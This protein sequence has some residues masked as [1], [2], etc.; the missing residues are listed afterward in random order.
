V[1]GTTGAATY[2]Y[3]WELSDQQALAFNPWNLLRAT[4]TG[5]ADDWDPAGARDRYESAGQGS[6]VFRVTLSGTPASVRTGGP[7]ATI[8]AAVAPI[9]VA[10]PSITWST[11]SSEIMLSRTTGPDVVVTGNL[12][13]AATPD[14]VPVIATAA[15]GFHATAWVYVE[16]P[17][18]APPVLTQG[19]TLT[20]P[21]GGQMAVD[22]AYDLGDHTDQSIITWSICADATCATARDVATSRDGLPL[23]SHAL[24]EGDVGQ[25]IR[26][27]VQP[28]HNVSD[29]G[30]AVFAI[31]DK[32]IAACDVASTTVSPNFRNFVTTADASYVSGLWTVIGTWTVQAGTTLVNGYGV[33]VG[34]QGAALLYQDDTRRGD[35]QV[36]VTMTPEKTS[37]AGFGS[38]GSSA[39]GAN[40]QKSDI[41]IKYDPRT[42]T[43]YSLRFW[44]TTQSASA[45][46]F[47]LFRIDN[48]IGT[49]LND[50]QVLTG[51]FRDNTELVMKVTG[52]QLT[53]E[54]HNT[55]NGET[56]SLAGTIT[57]N[58]FGGAGVAWGGT[59]SRGNSNVYSKLEI[60]YPGATVPPC[61]TPPPEP[62]TT[63]PPPKTGGGG[64]GCASGGMP[65]GLLPALLVLV[66]L[67][68]VRRPRRR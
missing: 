63:T 50:T 39:D 43:G 56:L 21:T 15:N 48:G 58:D 54:G 60:S 37:G 17:Y 55:A 38:P 61:E 42:Q 47:Q 59:V 18:E 12:D 57:P 4:P 22:Y 1:D 32:P 51:V 45:C 13:P 40:V 41:F 46:L 28:K 52:D 33:R 34:S 53:V 62:P 9:R 67:L 25:L 44:R 66:A 68:T 10:D 27:G 65:R 30:P 5:V 11:P 24:T 19:P 3:S 2:E 64:C 16:P 29:P 35:M 14:Y 49:P 8:G 31:S 7:G 6:V 23:K 26:V 20:G 36:A